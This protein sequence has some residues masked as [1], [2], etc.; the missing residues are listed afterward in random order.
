M[1]HGEKSSDPGNI[2]EVEPIGFSDGLVVGREREESRTTL[3]LLV[4]DTGRMLSL[5]GENCGSRMS[6][7]LFGTVLSLRCMLS[8]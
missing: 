3:K 7:F 6:G 1:G 2:P 8:I 5:S 4:R